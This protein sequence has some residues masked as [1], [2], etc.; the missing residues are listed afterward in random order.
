MHQMLIHRLF[1]RLALS[2]HTELPGDS[3][4]ASSTVIPGGWFM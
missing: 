1:T 2:C 4:L 3:R